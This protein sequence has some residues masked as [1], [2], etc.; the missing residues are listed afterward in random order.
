M[1]QSDPSLVQQAPPANPQPQQV[2]PAGQQDV[3]TVQARPGQSQQGQGH[4]PLT[5]NADAPYAQIE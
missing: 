3:G 1:D 4:Q 5:A 2:L